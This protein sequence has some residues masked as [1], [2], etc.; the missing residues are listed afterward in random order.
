VRLD[1]TIHGFCKAWVGART[2]TPLTSSDVRV[3]RPVSLA[4]GGLAP[5]GS[6]VCL[7]PPFDA[8]A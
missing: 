5:T 6:A 7:Q 2:R 4:T 3:H 1:A 8:D